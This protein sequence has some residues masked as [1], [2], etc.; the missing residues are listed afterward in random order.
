MQG[1][2]INFGWSLVDNKFENANFQIDLP[3]IRTGR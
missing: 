1:F 3:P 2:R